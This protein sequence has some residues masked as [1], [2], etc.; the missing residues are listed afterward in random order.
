MPAARRS[1]SAVQMNVYQ[2]QVK[3]DVSQA[4]STMC[5]TSSACEHVASPCSHE[6]TCTRVRFVENIWGLAK[7]KCITRVVH[8]T[9]LPSHTKLG[10][11]D[12]NCADESRQH[13]SG[14]HLCVHGHVVLV[15]IRGRRRRS[16][17]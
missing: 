1:P 3:I 10:S 13:P 12:S 4:S 7:H 16:R 11:P 14:N 5:S 17:H 8:Q 9:L 6:I 15:L 2:L